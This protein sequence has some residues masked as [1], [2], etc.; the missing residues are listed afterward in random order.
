MTISPVPFY[1][2]LAL[3][4][5][6]LFLLG[7]LIYTGSSI[8][9]PLFFAIVLAMLLLPVSKFPGSVKVCRAY[10]Q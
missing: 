5:I 3:Q 10:C 2:R 9:M 7:L 8:L 6:S 4:L 1:A